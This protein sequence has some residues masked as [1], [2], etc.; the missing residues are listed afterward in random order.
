MSGR[1][2]V[3]IGKAITRRETFERMM[4]PAIADMQLEESLGR[5]HRW[6][7]YGAIG[8]VLIHSMLH[9]FRLDASSAFDAEA[10][11]LAWR[12]A[13]IWYVGF[14]LLLTI[15]GLLFNLPEV[16][17]LDG[18]WTAALTS[19]GL[20]AIVTSA[21]MLTSVA[22]FY[23]YRRSSSRR[24]IVPAVLIVGTLT[25]AFALTVR[26]VRRSADRILYD[27]IQTR[28]A[29]YQK[30][31][32]PYK[33]ANLDEN[34]T[35]WRDIQSGVGVIPFAMFGIVLSRRRGWGVAST[36]VGIWATWMLFV[37]GIL[38]FGI[39][40]GSRP[41]PSLPQQRWRDIA[42]IAI[43]AIGWLAVDRLV[44]WIRQP[45]TQV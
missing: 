9:D 18:I 40:L 44:L 11:R 33:A 12:R 29:P 37:S 36:I 17:S 45:G 10:R 25:M 23:L 27:S 28:I 35:W 41:V 43:V 6:K 5:L 8:L 34:I 24:S 13:R 31:S 2:L 38:I 3:K 14:I 26:P 16:L 1:W 19:T 32:Y 21:T 20:E 15:L 42:T 4:A 7:H 39:S 22:V 30:L